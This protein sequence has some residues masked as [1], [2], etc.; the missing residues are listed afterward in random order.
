MAKSKLTLGP[1]NSRELKER[2]KLSNKT[3]IMIKTL[4]VDRTGQC[5]V[6][7]MIRK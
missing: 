1:E 6:I 4:K 2:C 3:N 7:F 5:R